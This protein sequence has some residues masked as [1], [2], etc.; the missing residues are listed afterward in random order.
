MASSGMEQV[1][2]NRKKKNNQQHQ[3]P[4]TMVAEANNGNF[5]QNLME[6]NVNVTQTRNVNVNEN[7][8]VNKNITSDDGLRSF[9]GSGQHITGSEAHQ[10]VAQQTASAELLTKP[11]EV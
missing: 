8:T 2:F 1:E 4:I 5:F 10:Q 3:V 7:V 6:N 11:L 9:F